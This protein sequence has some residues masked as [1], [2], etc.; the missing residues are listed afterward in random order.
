MAVSYVSLLYLK[1]DLEDIYNSLDW[2]MASGAPSQAICL[3]PPA[4]LFTLIGG[5]AFTRRGI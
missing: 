1:S 4:I 2:L 3:V 5:I